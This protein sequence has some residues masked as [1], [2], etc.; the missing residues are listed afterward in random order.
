MTFCAERRKRKQ[1]LKKAECDAC[2]KYFIGSNANNNLRRHMRNKHSGEVFQ[3]DICERHLSDKR[4][5]LRHMRKCLGAPAS[6]KDRE[7]DQKQF[8]LKLESLQKSRTNSPADQVNA[9]LFASISSDFL[10]SLAENG[11]SDSS[12]DLARRTL[13]FCCGSLIYYGVY[14]GS[15]GLSLNLFCSIRVCKSLKVHILVQD[16]RRS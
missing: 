8:I 2:P 10:N 15:D 5:K 1:R 12:I 4:S 3:C 6:Q 11:E 16:F 13:R 7:F 9:G 14:D